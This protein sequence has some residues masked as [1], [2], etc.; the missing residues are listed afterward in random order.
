LPEPHPGLAWALLAGYARRMVAP[1]Q[2]GRAMA[3]AMV[4]TA[5][6]LALGVPLGT[7]LGTAVGWR[8]TFGIVSATAVVLVTWICLAVPNFPGQQAQQRIGIGRVLTVPGAR[9]IFAVVLF[10]MLAH[11]MLYT[12]VAPIVQRAGL[13]DRVD[14][15]LL[16]FGVCSLLGIWLTGRIVDRALRVAVLTS[17]LGFAVVAT[18]LGV[19]GQSSTA[20]LV[21]AGV[22]G[23]TFGGAPTLLQT[24]LADTTGDAAEVAISINVVVWNGALAGGSLL[25]GVLLDMTGAA[26]LPWTALALGAVALAFATGARRHG[27]TSGP[28]QPS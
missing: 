13:G 2:Q 3:I 10:W 12:Y 20:V 7:W 22:W 27:L 19:A 23:L 14:A 26:A 15:V 21:A 24:A 17:L 25:G 28:R 18:A 5:L 9:P 4:G 16:V 6:A 11:N 1:E 8:S